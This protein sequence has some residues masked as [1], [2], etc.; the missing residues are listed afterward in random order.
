MSEVPAFAKPTQLSRLR[1]QVMSA[2]D[3]LLQLDLSPIEAAPYSHSKRS[4]NASKQY[5]LKP[6]YA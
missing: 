3:Q 4:H 6:L 2:K 1:N 5:M